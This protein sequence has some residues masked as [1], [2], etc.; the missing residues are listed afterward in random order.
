M[1]TS[2][3]FNPKQSL[4]LISLFG[5]V[6]NEASWVG[7]RYVRELHQD[8]CFRNGKIEATNVF[9]DEGLMVE[10]FENGQIAYAACSNFSESSVLKAVQRARESALAQA[11]CS[12]FSF[13][14][15]KVRPQVQGSYRSPVYRPMDSMSLDEFNSI[16]QKASEKLK[17]SDLI[18]NAEALAR[19][20]ET[21]FSYVTSSGTSI[22]QKFLLISTHFGATAQEG[23]ESQ[24]RSDKG[25]VARCL[26]AG[27]EIFDTKELFER[28]QKVG[29][30]AQELLKAQNCPTGNFDLLLDPDQLLL[31]IHE[32]I[33]HPLELDRILGD[34]RNYAGWSFIKPEDFGSLQ[35]GSPIMNITF[36]PTVPGQYAS[37]AFDELGNPAQ[38]EFLIKDGLLIRGLGSLESQNRLNVAGV[39]NARASSWNRAPIDRMA[40]INL[41]PG[42]SSFKEMVEQTEHGVYMESNTSWSIDDY[43]NKFQFG[44]EYARLIE[45]GKLTRVVK[46]PNYRGV[47]VPFWRSLAAVGRAE[48]V[49]IYGSPF[50]GKGEPSQ[51]IRV[52]HSAPPCLFKNVEVFGGSK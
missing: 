10:V 7:L 6:K 17:T 42:S 52:G 50:C 48:E 22:N 15:E 9:W 44:C 41:E 29:L 37:Y 26:Q 45:N 49:E 13:D 27:L 1:Q 34:E 46:N 18:I 33:G 43:R 36:D 8:R 38:K 30:Q 3:G 20:T 51:I 21:E 47:T 2:L 12:I 39:A 25:S 4:D 5:R 14:I 28:C 11:A 23:S 35:Y 32:S 31:Q 19:L 24:T 40:N 16:L